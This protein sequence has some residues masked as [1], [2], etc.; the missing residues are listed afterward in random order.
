MRSSARIATDQLPT[1]RDGRRTEQ[2]QR[3]RQLDAAA[4][5]TIDGDE[6]DRA[7]RAGDERQ[8]EHR[9]RIDRPLQPVDIREHQRREHEHRGDRVH[10]EVE[11]FGRAADDHADR[12]H[13]RRDMLA[14]L[15]EIASIVFEA[16]FGNRGCTHSSTRSSGR[17]PYDTPFRRM[18]AGVI[19]ATPCNDKAMPMLHCSAHWT[20]CPL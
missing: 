18:R 9:E 15:V 13:A 12:D 3:H 19:Y 6:D 4:I 8:R 10:E 14:A 2:E 11:E 16:R 5:G 20:N 1:H 17:E 7:D